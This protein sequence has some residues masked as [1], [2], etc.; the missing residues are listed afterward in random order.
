MRVEF[1]R[2]A[3][4]DLRTVSKESRAFGVSVAAAVEARIREIIVRISERPKAASPII[5]RP[6]MYVVPLIRYL[7]K[8]FYRVLEDWVRVLH[9][10]HESRRPWTIRIGEKAAGEP[11]SPRNRAR[12]CLAYVWSRTVAYQIELLSLQLQNKAP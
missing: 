4:E 3:T 6:G 5:E 11:A 9:I 8:I 10:R 1:T 12:L 7:Y 2:R